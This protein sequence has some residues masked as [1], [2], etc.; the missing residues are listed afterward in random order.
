[1][2]YGNYGDIF[3]PII[4]KQYFSLSLIVFVWLVI[5]ISIGINIHLIVAKLSS[6]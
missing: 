4:P 1:M 2:N 5:H 6:S 3:I